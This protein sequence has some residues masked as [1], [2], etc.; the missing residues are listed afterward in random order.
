MKASLIE[1]YVYDVIRR[2]PENERVE[3][4]KELKGNILDMLPDNPDED[5]IKVVLYELGSPA[6]LAEKYR[7]KRRYLISPALYEDY[8]RVLKWLVPVIGGILLVVGMVLGAVEALG[9]EALADGVNLISHV[10]SQGISTGASGAIQ[11][12]FWVTIGFA[13]ADRAGYKSGQSGKDWKVEDLPDVAPATDNKY[14]IPLSDSIVELIVIAVFSVVVIL[15]CIGVIPADLAF[16]ID[17]EQIIGTEVFSRSF[18]SACIPAT[19]VIG[20]LSIVEC[21]AKIIK[22]RWT[23][24]VCGIVIV[25]NLASI[26]VML[27]V[28]RSTSIFSREFLSFLRSREWGDFDV[29][30]FMG[31]S[32]EHSFILGFLLIASVIAV[33]ECSLAVYRTIRAARIS[34]VE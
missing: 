6:S 24:L 4:E 21:V 18:L 30:R 13:I 22:R 5:D 23:P 1:R 34:T 15:F 11:A 29:V 25:N 14:K 28:L 32:G 26:G 27:F 16:Y 12:M 20:G 33:I 10:F 8:V 2:L 9:R 7:Q 3:V 17:G 31:E 19:I